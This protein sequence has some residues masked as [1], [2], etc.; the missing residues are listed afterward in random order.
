MTGMRARGARVGAALLGMGSL[1]WSSAA[2]AQDATPAT[3]K[4]SKI[5]TV[6]VTGR[7]ISTD[8]STATKTNTPIIET[9]QSISVI[10]QQQLIL[11]NPQDI[12]QAISYSA[13]VTPAL[14]GY[15][16][17]FPQFQIRG[18]SEMYNAIYQ[19]GLRLFANSYIAPLLEPYGAEQMDIVRGPTSVLY[20][21]N[22]PGGLINIVSKR[23]EP[24]TFGELELQVG[25][26][27][28]YDGRWDLNAPLTDDD[29][30]MARFTGVYRDARTQYPNVP[31]DETY[32]APA[33]TFHP[34]KGTTLTILA[35]YQHISS[36]ESDQFY[37]AYL[38]PPGYPQTVYHGE[39]D[40]DRSVQTTYNVGYQFNQE[41]GAG[42]MLNQ[43]FRYSDSKSDLRFPNI[44]GFDGA[45]TVARQAEDLTNKLSATTV[46]TNIVGK[47]EM[48]PLK[49]TLIFGV[50]YQNSPISI[51]DLVGPAPDLDYFNPVYGLPIPQPT[52]L[53]SAAKQRLEQTGL[54]AQ[55]Q[56]KYGEHWALTGGL[57]QDWSSIK[58]TNLTCT[59]P[60]C[61]DYFGAGVPTQNDSALTGR[62]GLV[63][64]SD[65]GLA[66][67]V[68]YSTSFL[69]QTG[70]DFSGHVFDPLTGRQVEAG[71]RY[72]P[73][74]EWISATLS[75]YD[76]TEQH[77]LSPDPDPAHLGYSVET[78]EERSRGVE[79]EVQTNP[80]P[81]LNLTGAY[82]YD[83]VR[84][85]KST[86]PSEL[87]HQPMDTPPTQV[88][89]F[90]DYTLQ[91]G[92][93][94]SFGGGG[95]FRYASIS[96][97]APDNLHKN[98]S[99]TYF[100]AD[101]HYELENWRL[102]VNATNLADS[103]VPICFTGVCNFSRGRM[104]IGSIA[105]RF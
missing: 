34:W 70:T 44:L 2:L 87:N 59:D 81:G 47:L 58:T 8:A 23:P 73:K 18:F 86:D 28:R 89:V 103:N 69:P 4:D 53:A 9:P 24:D 100:D 91:D 74:S 60:D 14:F 54:Y 27:D 77:V 11:Q 80:Y 7:M 94:K 45:T 52:T 76:L 38:L 62:I 6:V 26:Y 17:R 85:T 35:D 36:G 3:D 65:I 75:V 72:L 64:L 15:D 13:G 10:N 41:F 48:G 68:S 98:G 55:D 16:P 19:D 78:G 95:G 97:D 88:L 71:I 50:D 5:E 93:L 105:R 82:T 56:I 33:I 104:I 84:I 42:W 46:D 25:S 92:P 96:Y 101:L 51:R 49:H 32:L 57:R 43:N 79:F 12:S 1:Q 63:Y 99:Q 66:P 61:Y 21:Q 67:Y 40:F 83:D 37:A 31:D 102:A 22:A 39:K 30:I 20:G 29:M 90:A